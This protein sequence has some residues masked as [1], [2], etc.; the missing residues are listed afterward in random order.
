MWYAVGADHKAWAD[1]HDSEARLN[2]R[3]SHADTLRGFFAFLKN[4]AQSLKHQEERPRMTFETYLAQG[5]Y[6]PPQ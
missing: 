1:W 5:Y 3:R 6:Y 2:G 4:R